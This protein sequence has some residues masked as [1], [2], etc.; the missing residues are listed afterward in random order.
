LQAATASKPATCLK[1]DI[2]L[3][4][5]TGS[6]PATG[7]KVP[8]GLKVSTGSKVATGPKAAASS[9]D[10]VTSKAVTSKAAT[11]SN[12]ATGFPVSHQLLLCPNR[13]QGTNDHVYVSAVYI[14]RRCKIASFSALM[15]VNAS[16]I[17]P[18]WS[19]VWPTER[20]R[21]NRNI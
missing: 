18:I 14:Q 3:K 2:A 8:T 1:P 17:I 20:P 4:R 5:P 13:C 15:V 9:K 16:S 11:G 19:Y 7:S 21:S 10:A 12:A 6:K